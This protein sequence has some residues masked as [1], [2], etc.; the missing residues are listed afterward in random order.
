MPFCHGMTVKQAF[1]FA[2]M[3]IIALTACARGFVHN[4]LN[5]GAA[6]DLVML[7]MLCPTVR[8]HASIL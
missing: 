1:N 5:P 4:S 7:L 6:I 2:G 8:V 3:I